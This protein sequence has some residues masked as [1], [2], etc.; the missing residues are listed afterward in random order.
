MISWNENRK[1]ISYCKIYAINFRHTFVSSFLFDCFQPYRLWLTIG[2]PQPSERNPSRKY[3]R[4][5]RDMGSFDAKIHGKLHAMMENGKPKKWDTSKN[6]TTMNK[7]TMINRIYSWTVE[8]IINHLYI[9]VPWWLFRLLPVVSKSSWINLTKETARKNC[10]NCR[11]SDNA[12]KDFRD[13]GLFF[14]DI[15]K[16]FDTQ[17]DF[18]WI[19]IQSKWMK[20]NS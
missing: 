9:S 5:Q 2:L 3:Q 20:F 18:K 14:A 19:T 15:L 13:A 11:G 17:F 10:S 7:Y 16:F 6:D 1:L 4:P 12:Q 8:V